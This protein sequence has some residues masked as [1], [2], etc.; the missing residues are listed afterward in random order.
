MKKLY[1]KIETLW[2]KISQPIRFLLVGGF[3]TILA[4]ILFGL[5]YYI[6]KIHY[7][8]SLILQYFLGVNISIFTMRYFVFQH[9]THFYKEYFKAW[10][11]YIILLLLNILWLSLTDIILPQYILLSQLLYIITTT[12]L[13]YICHKYYSFKV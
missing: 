8:I 4:Y 1:I 12:I 9:T 10:N 13:T 11:T 6:L 3:N 5:F 2:F 7:N